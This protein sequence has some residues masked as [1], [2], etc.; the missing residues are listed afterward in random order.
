MYEN[1]TPVVLDNG[2]G[3][4]K[5]GY[6]STDAPKSVFPTIV[7][8]PRIPGVIIGTEHRDSFI[9]EDAQLR[10]GVLNMTYPMVHGK[11]ENWDDIE[12]VWAHAF[13]NELRVATDEHP[14]FLIEASL[15]SDDNKEKIVQIMFEKFGIS[16]F[17]IGNQS[18]LSLYANGKISGTVIY[19]GDGVTHIDPVYEGYSFPNAINRIDFGGRDINNILTQLL[20]TTGVSLK[21]SAEQQIV[22]DIRE[23]HCYVSENYEKHIAKS[24]KNRPRYVLPDDNT[25]KLGHEL[26]KATEVLFSPEKFGL[27]MT[28][29]QDLAIS[30]IVKTGIE[31]KKFMFENIILS[32]GNTLYPGFADRVLKEISEKVGEK[33]GNVVKVKAIPERKFSPWVGGS[34]LCGLNSFHQNWIPKNEYEE[35]GA[36]VIHKWLKVI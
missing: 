18:I 13:Q 19:S 4:C 24:Q 25:L 9:G 23:K 6:A 12:K 5:I 20:F 11:V 33:E 35:N 31:F 22:R 28:S 2:S 34:Q 32:G 10:R 1:Q 7:G 17:Y 16:A 30:S 29:I 3:F 26:F 15:N 36:Q 21:T 14:V 27:E 8:K